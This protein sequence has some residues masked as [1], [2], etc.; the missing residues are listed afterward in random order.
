MQRF[1]TDVISSVGFGVESNSLR[2]E[3]S[4]IYGHV[5]SVK[6]LTWI[7]RFVQTLILLVPDILKIFPMR[8][9]DKADEAFYINLVKDTIKYRED[10]QVVR[11][12]FMQLLINMKNDHSAN[13][14][15]IY[16]PRTSLHDR[17]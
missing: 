15:A 13:G 7:R 14:I 16:P 5:V 6:V 17:S 11:N 1:T 2:D 9:M 4:V 8:N 12:D 10:N 3:N